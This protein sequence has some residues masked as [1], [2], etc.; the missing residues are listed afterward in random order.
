MGKVRTVTVVFDDDRGM[1]VQTDNCPPDGA[2]MLLLKALAS[3]QRELMAQ[4]LGA[5]TAA[6]LII[7]K[8]L[9][10]ES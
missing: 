9:P 8:G 3:V 10:I 4:R 7:A 1:Q 5:P 6:G 2:E